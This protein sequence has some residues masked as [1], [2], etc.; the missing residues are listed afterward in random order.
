MVVVLRTSARSRLAFL[1]SS[2]G[3]MAGVEVAFEAGLG[4]RDNVE[5]RSV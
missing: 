3:H 2:V 4:G 5:E 1:V